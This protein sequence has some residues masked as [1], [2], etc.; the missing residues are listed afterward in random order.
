[1]KF[2]TVEL[3]FP[4]SLLIP[5]HVDAHRSTRTPLYSNKYMQY[6]AGL[7]EGTESESSIDHEP[8]EGASSTTSDWTP[9]SASPTDDEFDIAMAALN[10]T[11]HDHDPSKPYQPVSILLL[12]PYIPVSYKDAV[13]CGESHYWIPAI[14]DEYDSIME[15]KTWRIV[16]L[17]QGRKAI[18]CKWVLDYKPGHKGVDPRYKARLVACGYDQLYGIDYLATYSP[19]VKHHSIRLILALVAAF[20]LEM[21]Q[22]DAKTPLQA[23]SDADLAADLIKRKS[24]TGMV[25]SFHGGPVSWGSKRQR[26]IALSTADSEFYAASECSRDVI[27]FR[28]IL[29]ELGI[30]VGTVPIMCDSSCARSIIEDPEE[31]K[32][33]KHIDIKYFFVREQQELKNLIMTAV[34]TENQ[35]ADIFTKPLPR[36]RFE[37]LR[38]M[39]GIQNIEE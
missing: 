26:A 6:R 7:L 30:I 23:Y 13:S 35:V 24:T 10:L 20:D 34:P 8:L 4:P 15:N 14:E 36:K 39:L 2:N 22:L 1:M 29:A 12:E 28:A 19:V 27:W 3:P 11:L 25:V 38:Q 16:P 32:R 18:K 37:M 21:I 5:D 33:I 17:P 31:H 9:G